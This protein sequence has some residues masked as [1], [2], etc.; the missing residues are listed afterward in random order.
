MSCQRGHSAEIHSIWTTYE[1]AIIN[2]YQYI[3]DE[4][5]SLYDLS[6]MFLYKFPSNEKFCENDTWSNI[7]LQ[8]SCKYRIKFKDLKE[9]ENEYTI[10]TRKMKLNSL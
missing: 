5:W 6:F 8:K 10:V 2:Y 1:S 3:K 7:K 4:G 9:L